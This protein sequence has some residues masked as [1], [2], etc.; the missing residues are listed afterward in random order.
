MALRDKLAAK[1]QPFL[2]DGAQVRQVF[3][4]QTGPNPWKSQLFGL[5]GSLFVKVQYRI[6]CVT[7]DAIYVFRSNG[8][9]QA[10][11]AEVIEVLHRQTRLGPVKG[12]WGKFEMMG[13]RHWVH[14]K[15]QKELNAAD[16]E[17]AMA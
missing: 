16:Q 14:R 9:M 12:I 2:P 8:K 1:C 7:Q 13:E 11:P 4:C 17:A 10:N 3:V 6:V 15:F 5:M